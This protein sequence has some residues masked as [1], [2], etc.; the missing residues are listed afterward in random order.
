MAKEAVWTNPKQCRKVDFTVYSPRQG[1]LDHIQPSCWSGSFTIGAFHHSVHLKSHCSVGRSVQLAISSV[2]LL[3]SET[4]IV[5][6]NSQN[7]K[8]FLSFD[9]GNLSPVFTI[10]L[11]T[12]IKVMLSLK[13]VLQTWSWHGS[14]LSWATK[15]KTGPVHPLPFLLGMRRKFVCLVLSFFSVPCSFNFCLAQAISPPHLMVLVLQACIQGS[16][17]SSS[18]RVGCEEAAVAA[19]WTRGNEQRLGFSFIPPEICWTQL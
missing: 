12:A 10:G 16:A 7:Y 15:E 18:L 13:R 19:L 5:I 9:Q 4:K 2:Y 11:K 17:K 1:G 3:I 6:L 8:A 14:Q